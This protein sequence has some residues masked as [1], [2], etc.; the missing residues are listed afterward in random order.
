MRFAAYGDALPG[1]SSAEVL[2]VQG[3]LIQLGYVVDPTGSYDAATSAAI[4]QFRQLMGL[5]PVDRIDADLITGFGMAGRPEYVGR[6]PAS[7]GIT[8]TKVFLG[9]I[10]LYSAWRIFS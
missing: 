6:F 2:E 5:P 10:A 8:P 9:V 3:R 1:S 7:S 4:L